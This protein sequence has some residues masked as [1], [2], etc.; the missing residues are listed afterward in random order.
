VC[1]TIYSIKYQ[2]YGNCIKCITSIKK[3]VKKKI[4]N[5]IQSTKISLLNFKDLNGFANFYGNFYDNLSTGFPFVPS[6]IVI[7]MF[8]GTL[9]LFAS[10]IFNAAFTHFKY[11]SKFL[12]NV[13]FYEEEILFDLLFQTKVPNFHKEH[14]SLS[15][16]RYSGF[17]FLTDESLRVICNPLVK[18]L[19][20]Q[21]NPKE[22][23]NIKQK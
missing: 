3:N 12:S 6:M 10:I 9:P 8:G 20:K 16:A 17:G 19:E 5:G 7:L 13:L 22:P 15:M 11:P 23:S 21:D 14:H 1:H 18:I 2:N 4:Y